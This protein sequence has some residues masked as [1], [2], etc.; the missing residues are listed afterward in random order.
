MVDLKKNESVM[1]VELLSYRVSHNPCPHVYCNVYE[2]IGKGLYTILY[3]W[4]QK[5]NLCP[6]SNS[7]TYLTAL[8]GLF[9]YLYLART[10]MALIIPRQGFWSDLILAG[11]GF[12]LSGQIGSESRKNPDP[13]SRLLSCK[14]YGLNFNEV[15][16]SFS[17]LTALAHNI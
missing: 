4:S 15:L 11:S 9:Y 12:N 14:F 6:P 10:P 7:Y 13:G 1:K 5:F 8:K 3:L 17:S 2:P 16:F